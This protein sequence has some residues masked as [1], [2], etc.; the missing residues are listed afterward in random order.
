MALAGYPTTKELQNASTDAKTISKFGNDLA[1]VPNINRVGNDVENMMTL[2]GRMLEAAAQAANLK[3]YQTKAQLS[4]DLSQPIN[5]TGRVVNDP[6]PS[7]NGDYVWN[8]SAWVWSAIQ[9]A[10]STRVATLENLISAASNQVAHTFTDSIGFVIAQLMASGGL[11]LRG[12]M[13][14]PV[15]DF[16]N[17]NGLLTAGTSLPGVYVTDDLGFV[18]ARFTSDTANASEKA[19]SSLAIGAQVRTD[20]MVVLGYGQSLSYGTLAQPA[21]STT[22]PFSNLMIASGT[23]VRS[24]EAGYD[25][26]HFVPLVEADVGNAGESPVTAACNGVVRRALAGGEVTSDW[27]FVGTSSGRSGRSVEQLMPAALSPD[28]NGDFEKM[29]A[30]VEDV[31]RLA[32][33]SGKSASVWAYC[34]DQGETNYLNAWTKSPYQYLQYQLQLFDHLSD[35]VVAKTGQTFRPYLFTYQV[36][37]HR[38]YGL[39]HMAIALAQ[40][41][42]SR[43][44][45]DVVVA[46]P[47]YVFPVGADSLHLTNEGSWLLGEYRARAIYQTMVRRGC[48]WRP[49]EPVSVVWTGA[50]IDVTFHVPGGH[51][52]LD[53][54]LCALAPN[55]GFDIREDGAVVDVIS[56]VSI[57]SPGVVRLGLSRPTKS[58]ALLSYGRG[59]NGDALASGPVAGARGNL[60]DSHGDFDVAVSPLGNSFALHNACVM[61]EFSRQFGF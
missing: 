51:L 33:A 27:V 35:E 19:G 41:R 2:R 31:A 32:S 47:V 15:G 26:S 23:K 60:R 37:A 39:D 48:K 34:W 36:G 55:F 3:T 58:D 18:I 54:A 59:R 12:H 38:K 61:F 13:L 42:A 11:S 56:S 17:V 10:S 9:P 14:E 8:G 16:L 4:A 50:A 44:R 49:L 5:A 45:E 25:A 20:L 21:I 46:A 53:E 7:N 52:V 40:W 57:A 28:G 1:G 24:G 22:Q 30:F 6:T 29:L 43:E